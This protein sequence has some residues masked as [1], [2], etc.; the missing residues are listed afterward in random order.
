MTDYRK[1]ILEIIETDYKSSEGNDFSHDFNHT[2][3][4]ERLAKTIAQVESAD[5]ETVEAACLLHDIARQLED[6]GKV[7]DHAE[8]GSLLAI[9]ILKSIKF[10]VNKIENVA[11]AIKVHRKSNNLKANTLE[12]KILQDADRL[13]A[14]GAVDVARVISSALQSVK[15]RNPIY[16]ETVD[17]AHEINNKNK[18][19]SA[20]HFLKYKLDHELMQPENFHTKIARKMAKG[21]YLFMKE[22]VKRF[23]LEWAGKI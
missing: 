8:T 20:I 3:R 21:R 1:K 23:E 15:Y 10:P 22:Y 5:I 12:A 16:L 11:H 18:Q 4:V 6:E 2:L 17:G 14:M 19:Q 13:D 7:K 9:K